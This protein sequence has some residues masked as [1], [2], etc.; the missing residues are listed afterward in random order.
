MELKT[1]FDQIEK[2]HK[3]LGQHPVIDTPHQRMQ[4]FRNVNLAIIAEVIELL[5]SMPWKPWREL[6]QSFWDT[7]NATREIVD[8]LFFLGSVLEILEITPEQLIKKF[9]WVLKNNYERITNGY[10]KVEKGGSNE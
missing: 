2:Y 8:I 1:L 6:D 7:D 9:E 4:R 3:K 10:S 5:D